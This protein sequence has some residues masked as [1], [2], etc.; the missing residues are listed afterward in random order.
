MRLVTRFIITRRINCIDVHW[1]R[2]YSSLSSTFVYCDYKNIHVTRVFRSNLVVMR[3][4][5][6]LYAVTEL[7]GVY[8]GVISFQDK[9]SFLSR[10]A[11]VDIRQ[12]VTRSSSLGGKTPE[13][14]L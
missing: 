7:Q 1:L 2:K 6:S 5:S 3:R 12:M 14:I 8:S 9:G 4:D 13:D 10:C 11:H